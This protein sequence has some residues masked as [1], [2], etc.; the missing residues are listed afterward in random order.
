M[1]DSRPAT[2]PSA[3]AQPPRKPLQFS[4]RTLL[5]VVT[6]VAILAAIT[7]ILGGEGV[8][9]VLFVVVF[10]AVMPV[11]VATLAFYSRGYRQ[12][13]FFGGVAGAGLIFVLGCAWLDD[14]GVHDL[15]WFGVYEVLAIFSSG[16]AA[17]ATR[18][19]L[20]R[21]GWHLPHDRDDSVS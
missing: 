9:M 6:L 2:P 18:R 1:S 5:I 21:R 19:F 10:L 14:A 16:Y 4:M 11:C 3:P 13:F 12:T 7:R 17:L 15:L 8:V 20:E